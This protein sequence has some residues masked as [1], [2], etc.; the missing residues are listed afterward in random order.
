MNPYDPPEP[1]ESPSEASKAQRPR[2]WPLLLLNVAF[3][4]S[5][6]LVVVLPNLRNWLVASILI[7]LSIGGWTL[8][9][10]LQQTSPRV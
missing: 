3:L 4:L 6:V 5:A 1:I 8:A 9:K 7:Y 2:L 10:H